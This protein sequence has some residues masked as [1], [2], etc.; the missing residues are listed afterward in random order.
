ML[1][2]TGHAARALRRATRFVIET[3]MPRAVRAWAA[4]VGVWRSHSRGTQAGVGL[5]LAALL[6]A[7]TY[8]GQS[9]GEAEPA[10]AIAP[11]VEVLRLETSRLVHELDLPGTLTYFQKA[12][13]HSKVPGRIARIVAEPGMAVR[14]GAPLAM[15]ETFDLDIRLRQAEAGVRSAAAGVALRRARADHAR[16]SVEKEL[17]GM[18]RLQA[19]IVTARAGFLNSRRA[20][21]NK[22]ELYELGGA[23]QMEL[24]AAHTDYVSSMARYYQTRKDYET[25]TIGYRRS[26]LRLAGGPVPDA[27]AD[28]RAAYVALNTRIET[29]ELH[30]A[31]AALKNAQLDRETV[32]MMLREAVV[33]SPLSGT[34]AARSVEVGEQP[35]PEEPLFTVVRLDRLIVTTAVS[36]RELRFVEPG[37]K[38]ELVVE[39]LGERKFPA[40]IQLISPV[41]DARTRS[42]ELRLF[43]EN[44]ER[45]LHPGMYARVRLVLRE[46]AAGLALPDAA[47]LERRP[48]ARGGETAIIFVVREGLVFRRKVVLGAT[49]GERVEIVSG[50]AAGDTVALTNL[51]LLGDGT[52]V[53]AASPTKTPHSGNPTRQLPTDRPPKEKAP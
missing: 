9:G 37:A 42:A 19:E 4:A 43:V 8:L 32:Q 40:R 7:L 15:M 5:I 39:A 31:E 36:E 2:A 27:P 45:L 26:D 3:V 30:A 12:A 50:I 44:P 41:V 23:S 18:Q 33:R 10:A 21:R 24:R 14:A 17:K 16:R 53:R 6:G 46:K 25:G 28:R 13:V 38:V 20:L 29:Q 35:K 11:E 1:A 52:N 51:Q 34:V 48:E 49:Y 22:K 47:L